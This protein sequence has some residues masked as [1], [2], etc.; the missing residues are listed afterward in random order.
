MKLERALIAL[1]LLGFAT[2]GWTQGW[3]PDR[4]VEI[5]IGFPPG[6]G[7]DKTARALKQLLDATKLV[8]SSITVVNKPGGGTSIAYTYVSQRPGD[9]HTVMIVGTALLTNHIMGKSPLN[10]TDFTPIA[11]LFNDYVAFSVNTASPIKNGT[12]LIERLKQDPKSVVAGTAV[13]GAGSHLAVALLLK[14]LGRNAKDLK[15]VAFKGGSDALISL[16]GGHIDLVATSTGATA[17]HLVAGRLRVVA[18]AAP[19]RLGG[20]F[21]GVPTWK[22]Q[23]MELV[24]GLPRNI[25]GPKGMASTR[26]AYWEDALRKVTET[27]EWKADLEK[28]LWSDNFVTGAQFRKDLDREYANFQSVLTDLGLAKR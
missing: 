21:A 19:T 7:F 5:V 27:A 15:A 17:P 13:I 16:L 23:G 20:A 22:E 26:S 25:M 3:S 12:D 11:S 2:A 9:G 28:H 1:A 10:Y 6:G 8:N 24:F 4:N 14:A 18:V